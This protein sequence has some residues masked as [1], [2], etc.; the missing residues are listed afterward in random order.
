MG[1][2]NTQL[3]LATIKLKKTGDKQ[4]ATK[5]SRRIEE[6]EGKIE[7]R[8][9]QGDKY[10]KAMEEAKATLDIYQKNKKDFTQKTSVEK[11]VTTETA[12]NERLETQQPVVPSQT[13]T[14]GEGS[15]VAEEPV[16]TVTNGNIKKSMEDVVNTTESFLR[17]I[18][19]K[20]DRVS[21][22][23]YRACLDETSPHAKNL[24]IEAYKRMQSIYGQMKTAQDFMQEMKNTNE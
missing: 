21:K 14:A 18:S 17:S 16:T 12:T 5:L 10:K 3:R 7:N 1:S 6:T 24:L 20:H 8:G 22:I 19:N 4:D 2:S 15:T 13:A 11:T 9:G 23:Y